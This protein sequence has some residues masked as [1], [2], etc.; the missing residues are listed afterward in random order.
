MLYLM[1]NNIFL[2]GEV[3]QHDSYDVTGSKKQ[4]NDSG[5]GSKVSLSSSLS[6]DAFDVSSNKKGN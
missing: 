2:V 3:S 1:I 5:Y 4:E 6:S